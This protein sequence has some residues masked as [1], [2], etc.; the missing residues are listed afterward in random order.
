MIW[1]SVGIKAD[2]VWLGNLFSS[3]EARTGE[4]YTRQAQDDKNR[5]NLGSSYTY[6]N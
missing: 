3:G 5:I 4:V 1:A 2:T 6:S